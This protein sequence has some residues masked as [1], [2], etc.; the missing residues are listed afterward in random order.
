MAAKR[1]ELVVDGSYYVFHRF[2]ATHRWCALQDKEYSHDVLLRHFENDVK[3]FRKKYAHTGDIW[4]A[5]DCSRCDI[6]RRELYPDYKSTRV[7]AES[8]DGSVFT[9]L[10]DHIGRDRDRLGIRLIGHPRLEADDICYVL[11]TRLDF[12][13]MIIVANDNDYL[14][15]C[16]DPRV[17]VVNKEGRFIRERGCGD[18]RKDLLCKVLMGDKSDNI[19]PIVRGLGPKTAAKLADLGDNEL[20]AWIASKGPDAERSADLNRR[21]IDMTCIPSALIEEV[22]ARENLTPP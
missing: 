12:D 14:Q 22:V 18:A 16:G 13:T 19:P 10:Y 20:R 2:Y 21:L 17:V 9:V 8:F 5:T 4:F 15:L 1:Q 3:M 7:H 6:W 11:Y